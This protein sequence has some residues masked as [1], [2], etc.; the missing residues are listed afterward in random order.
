MFTYDV[1]NALLAVILLF[2]AALLLPILRNIKNN[3]Q[4]LVYAVNIVTILLWVVTMMGYRSEGLYFETW[5]RALY[6]AAIF[7]GVTY[8][9]F[10]F[11]YPV[12]LKYAKRYIYAIHTLAF[13]TAYLVTLTDKII[14]S[15]VRT[16]YGEPEIIFGPWYPLYIFIILVPFVIGFG[17]HAYL[18]IN[19]NSKVVYLLLGYFISANVAFVTNLMLPWMG[20]FILNW[21][22]Q[23]FTVIMVSFTTYSILK[24]NVMNMKFFAVNVGV[25]LLLIITF[26]QMLFADSMRNLIVGGLVFFISSVTGGYLVMLSRNERKSLEHTLLLN[27]KIKKINGDLEDA[28]KRLLS[29]DKLKSEFISLASHQLRS[30]LTVIKGYASTLTD[31]VVGD[32]TPKQKEIATHIYT[33]A[34]G[35]AQVVEDFLNVTKIEQG[36]M[37]YAF[38]TI[39]LLPLVASLANDMEINATA[40]HLT[41]SKSFDEHVS[42]QVSADSVKLRQVFLNLVDNSIKYT[43]EGF[44]RVALTHD[45]KRDMIIFSVTDSGVG[46]TEETK[47]KLFTKFGRGAG[48]ALNSGG[49][50]LGLYLAQ[51]IVKAHKGELRADSEGEGKGSVFTVMLP[52]YK[53]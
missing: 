44:V 36:G 42:Y 43:K 33:S 10:T 14:V 35:L 19:H 30:P 4:T 3:I 40:K 21:V 48:A 27:E 51:E 50:G 28:N 16:A 8:M 46:L 52:A 31:G 34:Q 9:Q 11:F 22:G 53:G 5:L 41:F 17:R 37:Q 23:F 25:V 39:D 13:A 26:S 6:V 15:G 38:E 20:V 24:F 1:I 49:S 7:I 2:N 47:K 18:I 32:L 29:L 12:V 45:T